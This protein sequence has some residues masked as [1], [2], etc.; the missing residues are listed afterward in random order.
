MCC[1]SLQQYNNRYGDR[2][3]K[4]RKIHDTSYRS[5]QQLDQS[6]VDLRREWFTERKP[7]GPTCW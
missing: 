5:D 6:H 7:S 3:L 1:R 4:Q 2:E